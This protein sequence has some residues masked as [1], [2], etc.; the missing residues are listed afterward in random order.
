MFLELNRGAVAGGGRMRSGGLVPVYGGAS[1][2]KGH[3]ERGEVPI[4]ISLSNV[5]R[6]RNTVP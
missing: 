2:R 5:L 6:A 3:Q 1:G 4:L